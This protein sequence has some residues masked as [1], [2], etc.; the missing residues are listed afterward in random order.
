MLNEPGTKGP[1]RL[2]HWYLTDDHRGKWWPTG[3]RD[4]IW[5][6][7]LALLRKEQR[8]T[9]RQ[10]VVI[11]SAVFVSSLIIAAVGNLSGPLHISGGDRAASTI[12]TPT[13]S[14]TVT[15]GVAPTTTP[16][17]TLTPSPRPPEA[18]PTPRAPITKVTKMGIGVYH[19]HAGDDVV[20]NLYRAQPTVLVLQDPDIGFA[21][22]V[23]ELLPKA[24]IIG[25]TFLPRQ[26][27]DNPEARG[28]AL[29]DKV[30]EMAVPYKGLIDAWMSYNEP[31]YHNDYAAYEAYNKLQVA[32]A[33]R[34]QDHYGIPAVAGNDAPGAVE[35]EDYP[36]YFGE[37]IRASRYFGLHAYSGPGST[38]LNAPDAEYFALRYRLIHDEL[39]K[40]GIDD[41]QMVLT[42]VGLG[43]GWR[44]KV[45][46]EAMAEDF[47]WLADELEKDPYV[48]GM[49]IYGIFEHDKWFDFNIKNTRIIDLIGQYQP[50][51][52]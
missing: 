1:G 41:V 33:K 14:P 8:P 10:R 46:E 24:F 12:V 38:A 13:S 6:A 4:D 36:K 7:L 50:P 45:S 37:A 2:R 22:Q 23:R 52:K 51:P 31:V 32:F 42:E 30:S 17:P 18:T 19:L 27:L 21:R 34:L 28:V 26:P 43:P 16:G 40:A 15:V 35:P 48:I 39:E 11:L 44:G 9:M 5:S 3:V 25:R 29:A 49:A 47:M 20:D